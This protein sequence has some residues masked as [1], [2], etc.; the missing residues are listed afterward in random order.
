LSEE[1]LAT[2]REIAVPVALGFQHKE[3]AVCLGVTPTMVGSRMARLRE[4]IKT[5]LRHGR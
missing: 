1:G 2:L 3:V 5:Q 4:E